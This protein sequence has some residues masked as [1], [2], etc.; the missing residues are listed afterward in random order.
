MYSLDIVSHQVL[1]CPN[2]Y[3]ASFQFSHL[4]LTYPHSQTISAISQ[5]FRGA[6]GRP[7]MLGSTG[8]LLPGQ[9]ARIVR[10]DGSEADVDEVGEM[11]LRGGNIAMGYWNN[12]QATRETFV[13]DRWLRTGDR[14]RVDKDGNFL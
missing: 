4:Y 13:E 8:I 14:F 7:L 1:A 2:A 9:E 6:L 12:E 5:P 3:V 10:D 11:Y